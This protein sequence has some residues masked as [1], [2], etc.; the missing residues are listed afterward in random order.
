[1]R[2]FQGSFKL[3]GW[4]CLE[5]RASIYTALSKELR[6][7]SAYVE[8]RRAACTPDRI[9]LSNSTNQPTSKPISAVRPISTSHWSHFE[10][11]IIQ[12]LIW[13]NEV[14]GGRK[15]TLS[16][17]QHLYWNRNEM[18]TNAT[19]NSVC[20]RSSRTLESHA[21]RRNYLAER[22]WA[23]VRPGVANRCER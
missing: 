22:R 6:A 8:G 1:M 16:A 20:T 15:T 17:D 7:P 2:M 3:P 4:G 14:P 21:Q 13:H 23:A 5:E 10:Y 11:I 19:H 18:N 12:V 9:C